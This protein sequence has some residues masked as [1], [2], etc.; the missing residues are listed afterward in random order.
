MLPASI[1][2]RIEHRLEQHFSRKIIIHSFR[3]ISGGC[4]NSCYQLKTN[5]GSF[6]LKTNSA[7]R[8]PGMFESEAK[9]LKILTATD[10][11][12]IPEVIFF[13][14]DY[15]H[16]FLLLEF[17]EP[18][19]RQT[20]F[21][22]ILGEQLAALHKNT[23]EKFGLE[24]PNYIGSLKQ[25]NTYSDSW[26]DFFI[27]ERLNPQ[28]ELAKKNN[29]I[30]SPTVKLLENIFSHLPVLFPNEKP[31]LLHGDLWNGN[32]IVSS[33]GAP[34]LV[35]PAVYYGFREMDI[36]MTKLFGGFPGEFYDAYHQ[37]FPM[38]HGWQER[39]DLCNLYPLMVHVNLFGSGYLS[40]VKTILNKY[41]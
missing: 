16:S 4:I 25:S 5:E 36:A 21:F 26:I 13:D 39:L 37:T 23:A 40:E 19:R 31:A 29:R 10:T 32:I 24:H 28:L 34:C 8:Y 2:S 27:H 9:G 38:Q 12:N 6:F 15:D 1:I 7:S 20:D 11:I 41:R 30:D 22:E 17:I 33:E 18:G 3:P 35:D 14:N